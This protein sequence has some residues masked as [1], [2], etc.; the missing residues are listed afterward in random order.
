VLPAAA[1]PNC[2]TLLTDVP[3]DPA[4]ACPSCGQ[5]M[6]AATAGPSGPQHGGVAYEIA[7]GAAGAIVGL[8]G[9]VDLGGEAAIREAV[10]R[11]TA[12]GPRTLVIDLADVA[13]ADSTVVALL[14]DA[15]R[16]L[17]D[18]EELVTV[19]PP[20]EA[21]LVFRVAGIED[22]LGMR[23]TRREALAE[24]QRRAAG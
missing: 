21:R 5:P 1:C 19:A 16:G 17:G 6:T 4:A 15:R 18:D 9:E 11:A 13:F 10:G 12:P 24:L 14:L 20:E 8:R 23:E 3:E 2:P 22:F 7:L